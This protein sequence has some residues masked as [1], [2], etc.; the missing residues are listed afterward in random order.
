MIYGDANRDELRGRLTSGSE[1]S[2]HLGIDESSWGVVMARLDDYGGSLDGGERWGGGGSQ[3]LSGS[4][5][6]TRD[7]SSAIRKLRKRDTPLRDLTNRLRRR[8]PVRRKDPE[9]V[10]ILELHDDLASGLGHSMPD[11]RR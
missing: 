2:A 9:L 3:E 1:P 4:R 8:S 7:R 5:G 11:A 10:S 6:A